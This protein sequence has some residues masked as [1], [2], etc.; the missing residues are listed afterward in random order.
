[1]NAELYKFCL[2]SVIKIK[3]FYQGNKE[4]GLEMAMS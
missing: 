1:M 3:T 4:K 2:N